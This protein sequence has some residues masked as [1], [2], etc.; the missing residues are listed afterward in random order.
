VAL[1]D[2]NGKQLKARRRQLPKRRRRKTTTMKKKKRKKIQILSIR[3][4]RN[5]SGASC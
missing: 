3:L 5:A 4:L 2:E 1:K